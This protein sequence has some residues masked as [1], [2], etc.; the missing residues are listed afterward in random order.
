MSDTLVLGTRK[1]VLLFQRRGN[2]WQLADEWH[3]GVHAAYAMFD[4][5]SRS[6]WAC[7]SHGHWG[8]K[9][10]RSGDMG[11]TWKEVP[12]PKYPEDAKLPS[13]KP[14]TLLYPWV[15]Q[16]GGDD[17][18]GRVYLGTEPGGLF[19]SDDGGDTFS[20]VE[21]LWNHPSRDEHWMGGGRDE[22]GVHSVMVDPRDSRHVLVGV[23]VAGVFET[24]DGGASWRP[25]NRG[26]K[27]DFLPN[28][29]AEVGHDP[30]LV[31]A[32][33][34]EPDK[35][36]Q[37]NHCGIF[38]STDGGANWQR[39]S[40]AG[41]PAHFGFAVAVDA[42]DGETA[43]VVPAVSDEV[44]VACDRQLCV[45]RTTDGGRSWTALRD[46]LP[47]EHCYDFAFR[48]ALDIRADCLA[49]GTSGGSLF[50][51]DNRGDSWQALAHHLPPIYSVR[52]VDE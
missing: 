15:L 27:A 6:L 33:S 38:R 37:Q 39:V 11:R 30:H 23:S 4:R 26:L 50:V 8:P 12:C 41:G 47:Q 13:G 45:C 10:Q 16:A 40:E 24:A 14:A 25:C 35:L 7:L 36:W 42:E 44:R 19:A 32:S 1:G 5:R 3:E 20:L 28:P 18:P 22:A 43:W 2:S 21:P 29:D 9:L 46:G 17:E 49:F 52:F 51:S 34:A 31:V 48:H